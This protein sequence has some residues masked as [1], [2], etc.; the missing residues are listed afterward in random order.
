[1]SEIAINEYLRELDK[2]KRRGGTGNEGCI[3]IASHKLLAIYATRKESTIAR[4]FNTY[5][6][7]DYKDKV[8]DLLKRV[9]TVSVKT[10][11]IVEM[12]R[13]ME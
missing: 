13:G 11:E 2:I 6:F 5:R 8:I 12:M 4:F 7:A 1:M 3:S 10:M 9:C